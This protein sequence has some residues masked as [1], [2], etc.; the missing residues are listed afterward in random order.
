MKFITEEEFMEN[1]SILL[2]VFSR[3]EQKM[4]ER[5]DAIDQKFVVIDRNFN[6][7]FQELNYHGSRLKYIEDNMVHKS[8]FNSLVS[9]LERKE[10]ITS[11][12]K[13]HVLFKNTDRLE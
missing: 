10:V 2:E 7:V 3:L 5:F 8:Q 12:E 6:K 9:I 11:F 4:D 1:M 13:D